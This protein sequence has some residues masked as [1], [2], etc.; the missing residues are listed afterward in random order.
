M[1]EEKKDKRQ[2]RG[3]ERE[4]QNKTKLKVALDPRVF[5]VPLLGNFKPILNCRSP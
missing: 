5:F 2:E 1:S 3:R 4:K